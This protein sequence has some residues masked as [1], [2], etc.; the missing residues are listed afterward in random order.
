[1][2]TIEKVS[3]VLHLLFGCEM[4]R[5]VYIDPLLIAVALVLLGISKRIE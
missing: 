5:R 2:T 1:M 4:T 3:G